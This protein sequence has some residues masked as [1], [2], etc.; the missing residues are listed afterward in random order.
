MIK[1]KLKC[2][3]QSGFETALPGVGDGVTDDSTAIIDAIGNAQDFASFNGG[4]RTFK[5]TSSVIYP[6]DKKYIRI[7]NCK[8]DFYGNIDCFLPASGASA[9]TY[10]IFQDCYF[11]ALQ[12]TSTGKKIVDVS[13]MAQFRFIDCWSQGVAGKTYHYWG[14]GTASGGAAPYYGKWEGCYMGSMLNGIR[15]EDA[16]SAQS[17]NSNMVIGGRIQPSSGN[18]GIYL[19]TNSQNFNIIGTRFE[20]PSGG[21]GINDKSTTT[22]VIGCSFESLALGIDAN[23]S[24][25]LSGN[26]FDSCSTNV[27]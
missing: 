4:G 22:S 18:T 23:A 11:T 10:F 19:G 16:A 13:K 21:T 17:M 9:T 5:L 24:T 2:E 15:A 25:I 3:A 1:A 8:L 27:A 6:R 20:F 14:E 12:H 26:Y 7:K